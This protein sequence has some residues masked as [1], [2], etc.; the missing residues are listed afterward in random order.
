VGRD[1]GLDLYRG[2]CVVWMF[3]VHVR[4]LETAH[5]PTAGWLS[6]LDRVFQGLLWAE[7]FVSAAFVFIAG[8]SLVLSRART[9]PGG[10]WLTRLAQRALGL[11]LLSVGLFWMEYGLAL[12]DVWASSGI[13]GVIALSILGVGATLCSGR[14]LPWLF[15]LFGAVL[16]TEVVLELGRWTL[17]GLN[18][19]P[20]ATVP[21]V[22]FA[23]FGAIAGEMRRNGR[24][25]G[26]L[27]VAASGLLGLAMGRPWVST[28]LSSYLDF[29]GDLAVA[30]HF[31][32]AS[33]R[34]VPTPFWNH[35][36]WGTVGLIG[37]V[38]MALLGLT[39]LAP[40]WIAARPIS[41]VVLIGRHALGA[42]VGHL[43]VLGLISL[44][45]LGPAH[46]GWSLGYVLLLTAG[47]TGLGLG[48]EVRRSVR[49]EA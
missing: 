4:R 37:P 49:P 28:Q 38:L 40:A 14:P 29:A 11:Y 27:I 33:A 44:L 19:G 17:P 47:A 42:Y 25:L 12:P 35:T 43:L 7:P 34:L 6:V 32:P 46:A 23:A 9:A 5:R 18:A 8:Y 15:G 48:R 45:G 26:S 10:R 31:H 3:A 13:L 22:A 16:A 21:L 36:A 30:R 24:P 39:A 41:P 2:L 1:R 20:G